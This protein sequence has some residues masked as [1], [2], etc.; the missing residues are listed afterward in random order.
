[1]NRLRTLSLASKL[2][3]LCTLGLVVLGA[4]LTGATVMIVQARIG[5]EALERREQAITTARMLLEQKGSEF[6]VENGVL[7]VD[8]YALNG[9]NA[10]VDTI[11]SL[12]GGV[13]TLFLGDRRVATNVVDAE[14]KRAIGTVLARGPVHTA[15]F[16]KREPY[17]GEA[18]ILGHAYF[19]AYDPLF[20]RDGEVVGI[21]FV[22]LKKSDALRVLDEVVANTTMVAVAV[23]VAVGLLMLLMVRRQFGTLDRIRTAMSALADGRYETAVPGL[24][25]RD[26]IGAMAQAVEVFRQKG[27]ENERLREAQERERREAEAAKIA[28]LEAM[29]SRV[30]QETRAAVDRV[31]ERSVAMDSNA[32][33]MASSAEQVSADSQSVAVAADQALGNAQAVASAA[34]QLAASIREIGTQVSFASQVSRRAVE[35]GQRTESVVLSLS[36]AI[37]HIGEVATFIQDIAAQTNLLALNATIEAARAGDAGKGF[38]VVAH[39]V[40]NLA[41]QTSKSAEDISRQITDLQ[42]MTITA[43]DAV[44]DIGRTITE[45]DAVAGNIAAAMEQ[46]GAATS[47]ISR[48]V[49]ETTSAA[50]EVSTRIAHVSEEAAVTGSR[51]GEV[52]IVASD[53]AGSID[54]LRETLV[55]VVRTATPEVDRRR[56]PRYAVRLG[57]TV[58]GPAGAV[59]AVVCNLSEGG[60]IIEGGGRWIVGGRGGVAIDG[61][62]ASLPF[63]VVAQG[64]SEMHVKFD[65]DDRAARAFG[66]DFRRLTSGLSPLRPAA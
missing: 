48:N 62:A 51:A 3:L 47:E 37:G 16:E 59:P 19:T 41:T 35:S 63:T 33:A 50:Q 32:Q 61:C 6:R 60:A 40:K 42:S 49:L 22:G 12:N 21:L 57:C 28:A 44:K 38:A 11:H 26:E 17:R 23:T 2:T 39:E 58:S 36:E 45:I 34:E 20:N 65:L 53:V 31:A 56:Q 64:A 14:G 5:E 29:A 8:D 30:E 10:L 9:A 52:R 54:H 55:R 43:V 13:A 15:I 4:A 66:A 7:Y 27:L 46:Q 24:E 25:R 18:D 1:M